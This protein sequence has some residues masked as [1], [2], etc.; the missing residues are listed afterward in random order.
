MWPEVETRR[1]VSFKWG[2]ETPKNPREQVAL[3]LT[4][5]DALAGV[6]TPL[7][8]SISIEG[9]QSGEQLWSI[10]ER[11][12]DG[13]EDED[14][15]EDGTVIVRTVARVDRA[16]MRAL[17]AEVFARS[18]PT[19]VSMA[20][21][22]ARWAN[23]PGE[24]VEVNLFPQE[25]SLDLDLKWPMV[26]GAAARA[27]IERATVTLRD[28]GW[29]LEVEPPV[30]R[31][32]GAHGSILPLPMHIDFAR[33]VGTA[34]PVSRALLA[35]DIVGAIA[36]LA[37]P[38]AGALTLGSHGAEGFQ[39]EAGRWI[40]A[41]REGPEPDATAVLGT[42]SQT[43]TRLDLPV[44]RT[45][46]CEALAPQ[47]PRGLLGGLR[48]K[49]S[50]PWA[51][52]DVYL[53]ARLPESGSARWGDTMLLDS[54]EGPVS[55]GV[56]RRAKGAWS[57]GAVRGHEKDMKFPLAV[58]FNDFGEN[59]LIVKLKIHW[60]LWAGPGSPGAGQI[61]KMAA[62]IVASGWAL[63]GGFGGAAG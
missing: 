44:L 60:S 10:E 27:D 42:S 28:L 51:R 56:E 25:S 17:A 52:L 9:A 13:D 43:F 14:E 54:N 33:G 62:A 18:E 5:V 29:I 16:A 2:R 6:L 57:A 12:A 24:K 47:R 4:G 38:A 45:A 35:F 1:E 53:R 8:F 34:D 40:W 32:E 59:T 49:R 21:V 41:F 23:A 19:A 36:D 58:T 48:A 11:E 20:D 37:E 15:D 63:S 61:E 46:V 26:D 39:I 55:V 22:E 30:S 50:F 3:L 7:S 31:T